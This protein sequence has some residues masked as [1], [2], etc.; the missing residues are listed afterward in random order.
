MTSRRTGA[1]L[2]LPTQEL[3][4]VMNSPAGT[5]FGAGS[6]AI[7]V[8][9]FAQGN[10]VRRNQIRGRARAA[11]AVFAR[12]ARSPANTAFVANDL[13]GFQSSPDDIVIDAGATNTRIVGRKGTIADRGTGT[14][15]LPV[16]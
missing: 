1:Q 6:A 5:V 8:G 3:S 10:L 11:L 2:P 13:E 15:V 12:D 4:S 16:P 9:G 14:V 7:A